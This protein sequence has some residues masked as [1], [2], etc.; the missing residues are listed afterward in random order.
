MQQVN[1]RRQK[2]RQQ[3]AGHLP[4]PLAR[5]NQPQAEKNQ[6][7]VGGPGQRPPPAQQEDSRRLGNVQVAHPQQTGGQNIIERRLIHLPT[8]VRRGQR[9]MLLHVAD[10]F[11]VF[12]SVESSVARQQ[13]RIVQKKHRP[14]RRQT[15]RG[16]PPVI[17]SARPRAPPHPMRQTARQPDRDKKKNT[18][19]GPAFAQGRAGFLQP[20]Q[21]VPLAKLRRGRGRPGRTPRG[22]RHG[23]SPAF[24]CRHRRAVDLQA[25]A[26]SR[27]PVVIPDRRGNCVGPPPQVGRRVHPG[28]VLPIPARLA[29]FRQ[30][31][32]VDG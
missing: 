24:V 1:L 13:R 7:D 14:G 9:P 3:R 10:V 26:Q 12:G 19:P 18:E 5:E 32:P 8:L 29:R 4:G 16:P 31:D 6:R 15:Q 25:K 30:R 17:P 20:V 2:R 22:A 28:N 21:S 27:R 11:E 23:N